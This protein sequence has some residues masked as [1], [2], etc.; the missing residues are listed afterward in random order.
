MKISYIDDEELE[1]VLKLLGISVKKTKIS[2]SKKGRFK[3]ANVD[4]IS[5]KNV[6]IT[7]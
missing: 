2:G 3:K 4:L 1:K 5:L 7:R 6:Q